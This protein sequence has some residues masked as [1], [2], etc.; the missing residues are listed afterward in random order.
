MG[1]KKQLS[2]IIDSAVLS[3]F[4]RARYHRELGMQYINYARNELPNVLQ[5]TGK[6][7]S[8]Y[9]EKNL[10]DY[11]NWAYLDVQGQ[12]LLIDMDICNI[13]IESMQPKPNQAGLATGLLWYSI[14]LVDNYI[15][16]NSLRKRELEDFISLVQDSWKNGK[17]VKIS[18]PEKQKIIN[19]T[20]SLIHSG[21]IGY[22]SKYF[23]KIKDLCDADLLY[24]SSSENKVGS[25]K[26]VGRKSAEL[27]IQLAKQYIPEYPNGMEE[28]LIEQGI[29][30]K[31]FDDFKDINLDRKFRRGYENK[32]IP[33]LMIHGIKHFYR[34]FKALPTAEQ[35][36]KNINFIALAALFHVREILGEKEKS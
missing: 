14:K 22:P 7:H 16:E 15:D 9:L 27:T 2:N 28:F 4:Q 26:E 19:S 10:C 13:D 33:N 5:A 35:K 20:S 8:S 21:Y 11:K 18:S 30:G 24:I 1:Y 12:A 3:V 23:G 32:E 6:E 36:W 31:L 25:S 17:Q 34:H 29:T